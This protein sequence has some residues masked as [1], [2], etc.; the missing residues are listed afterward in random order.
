MQKQIK[1]DS[2]ALRTQDGATIQP[3]GNRSNLAS[4]APFPIVFTLSERTRILLSLYVE[5]DM[6]VERVEEAVDVCDVDSYIEEFNKSISEA[7]Q[8]LLHKIVVDNMEM[9]LAWIDNINKE[10]VDI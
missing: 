8:V 1:A 4:S 3:K 7:R 2:T 9:N 10:I 6:V 5:L